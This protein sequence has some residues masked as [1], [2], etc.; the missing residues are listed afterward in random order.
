MYSNSE[1]KMMIYLT[2]T[3]NKTYDK[4][5][6]TEL[7][8]VDFARSVSNERMYCIDTGLFNFIS[9]E[10]KH[11]NTRDINIRQVV[12]W[13]L[14]KRHFLNLFE[15][16][17]GLMFVNQSRFFFVVTSRE[18]V[19]KGIKLFKQK[20]DQ[21]RTA[22]QYFTLIGTYG[23]LLSNH[24]I[25][26]NR[27]SPL[28]NFWGTI[29]N[30]YNNQNPHQKKKSKRSKIPQQFENYIHKL[31]I[32]EKGYVYKFFLVKMIAARFLCGDKNCLYRIWKYVNPIA[33][34][35]LQRFGY[36]HSSCETD[37]VRFNQFFQKT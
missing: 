16:S 23:C 2:M 37:I 11:H 3:Q 7:E 8:K 25:S 4:N 13:Y 20:F 36:D 32:L 28:L 35:K 30:F 24:I 31:L 27:Q 12:Y 5:I 21:N 19:I 18:D 17:D 14:S 22:V 10:L 15:N 33:L 9:V 29:N 34:S 1:K 6:T 26:I